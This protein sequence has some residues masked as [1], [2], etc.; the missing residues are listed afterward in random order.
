MP[1]LPARILQNC[2]LAV[3]GLFLAAVAARAVVFAR[4]KANEVPA[5]ES[6]ATPERE[7]PP[8]PAIDPASPYAVGSAV[9]PPVLPASPG[10]ATHLYNRLD[11]LWMGFLFLTFF[12]MGMSAAR[13][14]EP[15]DVTR[16]SADALAGSIGFWFILA[17]VTALIM[18]RRLRPS[19]WL[20]LR[21]KQWPHV[22]WIAPATVA[23]MWGLLIALQLGGYMKWMES[24]GGETTQDTI[25]F[26]QTSQDPLALGLM[27]FAAVIAAPLCEETVFRGY[28]YPA[29]KRFAG[30]GA[31]ALCSAL[32]FAAAHSN[33]AALLPLFVLGLILVWLYERTGSLWAPIAVHFCFNGA[34]VAI[35]AAARYFHLP[36]DS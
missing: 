14:T 12:A 28:L 20:G 5:V 25:K 13:Q 32:L 34:T 1:D 27:A 21:W 35:Q 8:A 24:L 23:S 19:A 2:F 29:A 22:L 10:V 30:P 26:L 4:S 16:I 3:P 17:G 7:I 18:A 31:A 36:L 15:L 11:F 6:H 33:L 9:P